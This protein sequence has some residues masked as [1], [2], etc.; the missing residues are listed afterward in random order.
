MYIN[1]L[2]KEFFYGE[3]DASG[4]ANCKIDFNPAPI[5]SCANY[6]NTG[7]K[8]LRD[9]YWEATSEKYKDA[10]ADCKEELIE[11][12]KT[13]NNKSLAKQEEYNSEID[14]ELTNVTDEQRILIENKKKMEELQ[15]NIIASEQ[16]LADGK[17]HNYRNKIKLIIFI[18]AIIVF[19]LIEL[20]L[21]IV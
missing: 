15:T 17:K 2:N 12:I 7:Y 11:K 16:R 10:S 14:K 18:V 20:I 8:E 3:H 9:K 13:N 19:V 1:Y 5:G 6:S 4:D 21:I